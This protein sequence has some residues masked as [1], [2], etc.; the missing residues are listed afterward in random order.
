MVT[1]GGPGLTGPMEAW[2]S[3]AYPSDALRLARE[4]VHMHTRVHKAMHACLHYHQPVRV[5]FSGQ[6][7]FTYYQVLRYCTQPHRV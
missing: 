5:F 7:C 2:P 6:F 3:Q 4:T 1:W